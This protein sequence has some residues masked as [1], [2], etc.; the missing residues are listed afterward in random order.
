MELC[1]YALVIV[2]FERELMRMVPS[3]EDTCITVSRLVEDEN[4]RMYQSLGTPNSTASS[5]CVTR[6]LM[7]PLVRR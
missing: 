3:E 2:R 7:E 1:G 4:V 5:A 6:A